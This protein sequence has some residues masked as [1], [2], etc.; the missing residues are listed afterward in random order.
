MDLEAIV[1]VGILSFWGYMIWLTVWTHR[2]LKN[3]W[4]EQ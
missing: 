2:Q 4:E 1:L 3:A